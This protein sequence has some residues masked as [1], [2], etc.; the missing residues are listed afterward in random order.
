MIADEN[1]IKA[2]EH[3]NG[4]LLVIAGP[5]SGKTRVLVERIINLVKNHDKNPNKF[6]LITFTNKAV[7]ELKS[8][9]MNEFNEK[10]LSMD[11][12]TIHSF[13]YKIL[14]ENSDYHNFSTDFPILDDI[15][16]TMFISTHFRELK[17]KKAF[18]QS[19]IKQIQKFF[20]KCSENEIDPFK[21][22]KILTES[23]VATVSPHIIGD[24]NKK[25]LLSN[26]KQYNKLK[27]KY[28]YLGIAYEKYLKLLE[29]KNT[30]D[31][32]NLQRKAIELLIEND[33]ILE[34]I[35]KK[36]DFILIDE[37]QDVN[38]IQEKLTSLLFKYNPNIAVVGDD[39][40][41]IYGFRGANVKNFLNFENKYINDVEDSEKI[42]LDKNYRSISNIVNVSDKFI[43]D[44]RKTKKVLKPI[45]KSNEKV[46]L[47]IN[48]NID[49]EAE[50]VVKIIKE[51]KS[52]NKIKN[53]NDILLLSRSVKLHMPIILEK[54]EENNIPFTTQGY[55]NFLKQEEIQ[56]AL[57]LLAY[58]DRY[59]DLKK[60]KHSFYHWEMD[61]FSNELLLN[62][63]L[64]LSNETK[65]IIKNNTAEY[66][67]KIEKY[68]ERAELKNIKTFKDFCES[69]FKNKFPFYKKLKK[70]IQ[71]MDYLSF[72]TEKEFNSIGIKNKEDIDKFLKLRQIAEVVRDINEDKNS[73]FEYENTELHKKFKRSNLN[74]FFEILK[75]N[76]Y[77]KR[78]SKNLTRENK[79]KILNLAKIS[80]I[81]S[82]YEEINKNLLLNNF[83]WYMY[84][85]GNDLEG[86]TVKEDDAVNV[87]TI[88]KAKGLESPVVISC[89]LTNNRSPK[90]YK[91]NIEHFEIPNEFYFLKEYGSYWEK[92]VSLGDFNLLYECYEDFYE[93]KRADFYREEKSIQYVAMTRAQDILILSGNKKINK[94][95]KI[96]EYIEEIQKESSE[97]IDYL[98][99]KDLSNLHPIESPKK[100][101]KEE[102]FKINYSAIDN[103]KRCPFLYNMSYNYGFKFPVE[104]RQGLGL[105]VHESVFDIHKAIKNHIKL[106]EADIINILNKNWV[107]VSDNYYDNENKKEETL[108]NLKIY[109]KNLKKDCKEI[110]TAEEPFSMLGDG[111]II[112]GKVDLIYKNKNDEVEII[113]FKTKEYEKIKKTNVEMQLSIYEL[114]FKEKY[115][116]DKL[117]AYTFLD[118]EKYF[119]EKKENWEYKKESL[120]NEILEIA[121]KIKNKEFDRTPSNYCSVCK[122]NFLCD[123]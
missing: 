25:K 65:E 57:F 44:K 118:H 24:F 9:L 76:G 117:G 60:E 94:R 110:L 33:F 79:I 59:K 88:H 17:L 3:I 1:Q 21:L 119:I 30:L 86:A 102:L 38:N 12:S 82:S 104:E 55:G 28:Y 35:A 22:K 15:R 31:F 5:G 53:Y 121:N 98:K 40:Q 70:E 46:F 89:S 113:D 45:R 115:S 23:Y 107:E 99:I 84:R 106:N 34:K 52:S 111:Y 123:I 14:K 100:R 80:E 27:D 8:R 73:D 69:S 114:A 32:S 51:L 54:L 74:I 112:E 78:L 109:Y 72:K 48:E 64:D 116:P 6:L 61:W 16:Q 19:E 11:I 39:D 66:I 2:I 68:L 96:S 77:L 122:F 83:L 41:S 108:N 101:E 62:E 85:L 92:L 43:E 36:Y 87:S 105:I 7:D 42:F 63:F 93:K 103:Y 47:L 95:G 58:V 4:P 29:E 18:E 49:E 81:I 90:N 120:K 26:L 50:N 10:A 56:T 20:D 75:L 91:K 67:K 37:Y 71:D 13:C 97:Y